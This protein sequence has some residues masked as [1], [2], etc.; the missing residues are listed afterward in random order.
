MIRHILLATAFFG[1]GSTGLAAEPILGKKEKEYCRQVRQQAV[2]FVGNRLTWKDLSCQDLVESSDS[3][4]ND[5]VRYSK[6]A[7]TKNLFN[8]CYL[9]GYREGAASIIAINTERCNNQAASLSS[10]AYALGYS[11]CYLQAS[12]SPADVFNFELL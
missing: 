3:L 4:Y 10:A 7:H 5:L 1:L 2:R 9:A 6:R 11:I 8:E 12:Q